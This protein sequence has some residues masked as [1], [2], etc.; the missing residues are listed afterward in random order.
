MAADEDDDATRAFESLRAE[1]TV[2]RRAVEALEAKKPKDYNPTLGAMTAELEK[3]AGATE[4]MARRPALMLTPEAY[5]AQMRRATAEAARPVTGELQRAQ[6][7][8]AQLDQALGAVRTRREQRRWLW[9]TAGAGVAL[10]PLLWA[11]V[12][13]PLAHALPDSWR[14]P[15]KLA[16]RVMGEDR[17]MAGTRMAASAAP[18]SWARVVRVSQLEE[19]NREALDACARDAAKTGRRQ[20]CT[21]QVDPPTRP[22]PV[23]GAGEAER[24]PPP[25]TP[26]GN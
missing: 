2:M 10:G 1:V 7:L 3:L 5:E 24:D 6:N 15:E 22:S 14:L 17:W 21:V 18:E 19:A 8:T 25:T 26:A 23:P 13:V 20:R 12:V 16:A 11:L 4:A 9:A